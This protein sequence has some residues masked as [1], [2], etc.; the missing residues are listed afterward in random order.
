[1][2]VIEILIAAIATVAAIASAIAA[3]TLNEMQKSQNDFNERITALEALSTWSKSH[4]QAGAHCMAMLSQYSNQEFKEFSNRALYQ[5]NPDQEKFAVRCFVAYA[6]EFDQEKDLILNNSEYSY[7]AHQ[8]VNQLNNYE[9]LALY[10]TELGSRAKET[11]C[12]QARIGKT[13]AYRDF[14]SKAIGTDWWNY[15]SLSK[16]MLECQ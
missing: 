1:M 11:I 14:E 3:T 7:V 9:G 4:T 6:G 13:D 16:F 2:K 12:Q 15:P 8:V 5:L 10:W